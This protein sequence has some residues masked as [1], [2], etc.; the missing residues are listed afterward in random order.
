MA[1]KICEQK[2]IRSQHSSDD[3]PFLSRL[4]T[5]YSV[6]VKSKYCFLSPRIRA[7]FFTR[8]FTQIGVWCWCHPGGAVEG[9]WPH[10][11]DCG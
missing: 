2:M 3:D 8:C 9:C 1:G 10:S 11:F 5:D 7:A 4:T 6:A